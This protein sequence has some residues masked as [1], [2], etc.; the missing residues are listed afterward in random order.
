MHP[1]QQRGSYQLTA[2]SAPWYPPLDQRYPDERTLTVEIIRE[3]LNWTFCDFTNKYHE[4]EHLIL[5]GSQALN[6]HFREIF[7]EEYARIK[8]ESPI[9]FPSR[10]RSDIDLYDKR[11]SKESVRGELGFFKALEEAFR[12]HMGKYEGYIKFEYSPQAVTDVKKTDLLKQHDSCIKW[13]SILS[14]K[15]HIFNTEIE[16]VQA[17]SLL[18][19]IDLSWTEPELWNLE[20]AEIRRCA[21]GE[22]VLTVKTPP[23]SYFIRNHANT[24][25][26]ASAGETIDEKFRQRLAL[27]QRIMRESRHAFTEEDADLINKACAYKKPSLEAIPV[28]TVPD[29]QPLLTTQDAQTEARAHTEPPPKEEEYSTQHTAEPGP[30]EVKQTQPKS[31]VKAAAP[32]VSAQGST[33]KKSRRQLEIERKKAKAETKR[34]AKIAQEKE[35]RNKEQR[36]I[37]QTEE[38]QLK[39]EKPHPSVQEKTIEHPPPPTKVKKTPKVLLDGMKEYLDKIAELMPISWQR[40]E[41]SER[42]VLTGYINLITLNIN[43]LLAKCVSALHERNQQYQTWVEHFIKLLGN[44]DV[45]L[46]Y[47]TSLIEQLVCSDSSPPDE[48]IT[49]ESLGI[50]AQHLS[51]LQT[52]RNAVMHYDT[53][54]HLNMPDIETEIIKLRTGHIRNIELHR[55]ITRWLDACKS[56]KSHTAMTL[57]GK[58]HFLHADNIALTLHTEPSEPVAH[59]QEGIERLTLP[60]EE[61]TLPATEQASEQGHPPTEPVDRKMKKLKKVIHQR[62]SKLEQFNNKPETLYHDEKMLEKLSQNDVIESLKILLNNFEKEPESPIRELANHIH[63]TQQCLLSFATILSRRILDNAR[64]VET[65]TNT[66][67][68]LI[69]T[70]QMMDTCIKVWA[71]YKGSLSSCDTQEFIIQN[72][73]VISPTLGF[74]KQM[75][76]YTEKKPELATEATTTKLSSMGN[77]LCE[78]ILEHSSNL[79]EEKIIFSHADSLWRFARFHYL[80]TRSSDHLSN[81]LLSH[82]DYT[83]KNQWYCRTVIRYQFMPDDLE[84][85]SQMMDTIKG[86]AKVKK[87]VA[88]L[89]KIYLPIISNDGLSIAMPL[90]HWHMQKMV[91]FTDIPPLNIEAISAAWQRLHYTADSKGFSRLFRNYKVSKSRVQNIEILVRLCDLCS[92]EK[93]Q[94]ELIHQ[95]ILNLAIAQQA[96]DTWRD[97]LF[98][99]NRQLHPLHSKLDTIN[100]KIVA[101]LDVDI[102]INLDNIADLFESHHLEQTIHAIITIYDQLAAEKFSLVQ[103]AESLKTTLCCFLYMIKSLKDLNQQLRT[104]CTQPKRR[105][106]AVRLL[107]LSYNTSI[108]LQVNCTMIHSRYSQSQANTDILT[109]EQLSGE[110]TQQINAF[111]DLLEANQCLTQYTEPSSPLYTECCKIMTRYTYEQHQNLSKHIQENKTLLIEHVEFIQQWVWALSRADHLDQATTLLALHIKTLALNTQYQQQ[112]QGKT[113]KLSQEQLIWIDHYCYARVLTAQNITVIENERTLRVAEEI[114]RC[115]KSYLSLQKALEEGRAMMMLPA[116]FTA[117]PMHRQKAKKII[118]DNYKFLTGQIVAFRKKPKDSAAIEERLIG[119]TRNIAETLPFYDEEAEL[120]AWLYNLTTTELVTLTNT[121]RE[122]HI[123][124]MDLTL[125][126]ERLFHESSLDVKPNHLLDTTQTILQLVTTYE[127]LT[128]HLMNFSLTTHEKTIIFEAYANLNLWLLDLKKESKIIISLFTTFKIATTETMTTNYYRPIR[129]FMDSWDLY[130]HTSVWLKSIS[131][132]I[133]NNHSDSLGKLYQI[134]KDEFDR[135]FQKGK[136]ET[137]DASLQDQ[138]TFIYNMAFIFSAFGDGYLQAKAFLYNLNNIKTNREYRKIVE[139]IP[140]PEVIE[141]FYTQCLAQRHVA[142]KYVGLRSIH[143]KEEWKQLASIHLLF[144]VYISTSEAIKHLAKIQDFEQKNRFTDIVDDHVYQ[145]LCNTCE[146][147][148]HLDKH[149]RIKH[150]I[151]T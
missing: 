2:T 94:Q 151:Y 116:E 3:Q 126:M 133:A 43:D 9:C 130:L 100:G 99:L 101:L 76:E 19:R 144:E 113:Y 50:L 48:T 80:I 146:K 104:Y 14:T 20:T 77:M 55:N 79:V 33:P 64:I 107:M 86:E 52:A 51:Q 147:I 4:R 61:K 47:T 44:I 38:T 7:G 29:T 106:M 139:I 1:I 8:D 67:H 129:R 21:I 114:F 105:D 40:M 31:D 75:M 17:Q 46:N 145:E 13:M 132:D 90:L 30:S 143:S 87:A 56:I 73:N 11:Q 81:L 41:E 124:L 117:M 131:H 112:Y 32:T 127:I 34:K 89:N 25:L 36:K 134:L 72:L 70:Y 10:L 57:V 92:K 68:N 12:K 95:G 96:L 138:A 39:I 23:L 149:Y 120:S 118:L 109:D 136:I 108:S 142:D 141:Q 63:S 122:D 66:I 15:P 123:E 111:R 45:S 27:L 59:L 22:S 69:E 37:T 93:L 71:K 121:V 135:L 85:C 82:L 24:I 150:K 97:C 35:K 65:C 119:V 26:Y 128:I 115:I 53:K 140:T 78:I 103:H 148:K 58:C 5:V 91:E 60:S 102:N 18:L 6:Q 74:T 98:P 137:M 28:K 84:T 54:P 88:L 49:H 42:E 16:V 110:F 83:N 125:T 62:K